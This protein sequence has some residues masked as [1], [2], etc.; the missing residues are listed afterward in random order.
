M[1]NWNLIG[2]AALYGF[3]DGA[4]T[5]V[6]GWGL[7]P[8]TFNFGPGLWKMAL[9]ALIKGAIGAWMNARNY[10]KPPPPPA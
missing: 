7:A 4:F 10:M 1:V 6:I 8:E 5:A 9:L 3:L 2:V